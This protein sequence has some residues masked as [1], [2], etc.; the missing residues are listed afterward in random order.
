MSLKDE[1]LAR[2]AKKDREFKARFKKGFDQL[3]KPDQKMVIGKMKAMIAKRKYLERK[4]L[5]SE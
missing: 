2:R 4:E 3:E 1:S 5:Q